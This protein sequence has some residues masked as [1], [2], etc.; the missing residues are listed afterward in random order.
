MRLKW[1]TTVTDTA[2]GPH[3]VNAAQIN[4]R[5]RAYYRDS[6]QPPPGKP[7]AELPA[8][9]F[10]IE[11]ADGVHRIYDLVGLAQDPLADALRL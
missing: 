1:R 10:R 11:T 9:R 6:A 8:D 7:V 3:Q 5:N 4:E 2:P